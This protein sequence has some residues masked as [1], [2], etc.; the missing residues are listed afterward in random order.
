M[1][2]EKL[3]IINGYPNTLRKIEIVERQLNY[4]KKLGYPILFVSGCNVPSSILDQVDYFIL[5]TN[6]E[7]LRKDFTY[8]LFT[9]GHWEAAHVYI[10]FANYN[11]DFYSK[12]YQ[13][14]CFNIDFTL[15]GILE[16]ETTVP[17]NSAVPILL[18]RLDIDA[19]L[20]DANL[21]TAQ[22]AKKGEAA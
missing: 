3:I 22:A 16:K 19:K 12:K 13:Y 14:F 21:F 11:L 5:N 2:R 15:S 1:D 20:P 6:N 7:P 10:D 8:N 4:L 18:N 9:L 17:T